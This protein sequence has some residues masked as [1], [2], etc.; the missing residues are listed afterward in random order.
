MRNLLSIE[1]MKML[2]ISLV[3]ALTK[4][5]I[6]ASGTVKTK[7]TSI[8]RLLTAITSKPGFKCFSWFFCFL[9]FFLFTS[10]LFY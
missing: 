1:F 10:M 3:A 2:F 4:A 8:Y 9:F 7:F 6:I 5:E